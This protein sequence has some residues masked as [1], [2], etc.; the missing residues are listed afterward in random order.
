FL[1]KLNEFRMLS[2]SV[3]W[4]GR[5]LATLAPTSD[6]FQWSDAAPADDA[7]CALSRFAV[8]RRLGE[9]LVLESPVGHA[10]VVLHAPEAAAFVAALGAA[11]P[12]GEL[13]KSA[14][15]DT[16]PLLLHL[17]ANAGALATDTES[18]ALQQWDAHDLYFHSRCR[19]GRHANPF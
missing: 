14:P 13:A 5:L 4:E 17:L 2:R 16:A 19:L 6:R 3:A 12:G 10:R 15:G 11:R 18:V 8:M 9:R 1:G 7:P